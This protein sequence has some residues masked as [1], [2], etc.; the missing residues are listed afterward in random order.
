MLKHEGNPFLDLG[1]HIANFLTIE[2]SLIRLFC[3]MS[4]LAVIQMLIFISFYK[5]SIY[6]NKGG[7]FSPASL[8]S[9]GQADAI[10]SKNPYAEDNI[11]NFGI[12]CDEHY[13]ID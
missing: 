11:L 7:V 9:L 12:M 13:V 10:C 3:I 6:V 2:Q 5:S 1:S 8:E 4:I